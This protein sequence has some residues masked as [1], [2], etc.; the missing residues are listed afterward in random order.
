MLNLSELDEIEGTLKN[1]LQ[2]FEQFYVTVAGIDNATQANNQ[3]VAPKFMKI[4]MT[5][6]YQTLHYLLCFLSD[7]EIM[8]IAACCRAAYRLVYSPLGFR[9]MRQLRPIRYTEG[10]ESSSTDDEIPHFSQA[11]VEQL[12]SDRNLESADEDDKMAILLTMRTNILATKQKIREL[13]LMIQAYDMKSDKLLTKIMYIG[14]QREEECRKINTVQED[15]E[16]LRE[17]LKAT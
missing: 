6:S 8:S 12:C 5:N 2:Q 10:K 15:I 3:I 4:F 16:K 9:L 14:G 1:N 13:D 17:L 11:T 7:S